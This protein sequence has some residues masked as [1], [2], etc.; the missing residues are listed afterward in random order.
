VQHKS[1]KV[2]RA[3][4]LAMSK[5]TGHIKPL[6][7]QEGPGTIWLAWMQELNWKGYDENVLMDVAAEVRARAGR[8]SQHPSL[9]TRFVRH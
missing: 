1:G 9:P 3:A 8:P 4:L 6:P 7:E 2:Q 5:F